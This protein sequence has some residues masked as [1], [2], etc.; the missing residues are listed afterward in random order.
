MCTHIIAVFYEANLWFVMC[1]A[2][3]LQLYMIMNY[4]N[5][6]HLCITAYIHSQANHALL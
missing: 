4:I 1:D 2:I 5:L 6:Y 3:N